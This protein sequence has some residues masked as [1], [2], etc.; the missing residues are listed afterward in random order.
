MSNCKKK[1]LVKMTGSIACFKACQLIS[2]LMQN[3]F[4]VQIV[5]SQAALKFIGAATLEG[6][7]G[8]KVISDLWE[9]G[10]AMAHIHLMRWADLI[11]VVPASANFINRV[12]QG[13]GEDLLTTL[14]LAHDFKKPYLI[15][16]AM[17]TSMYLHPVTQK[18]IQSLK[19]M[20]LI[21][22]ESASGVL[23]CGES[24]YGRLLE[25]DQ[26]FA[27]IQKA[28]N[29]QVAAAEIQQKQKTFGKVLITAGGTQE[30]IDDVR[31]LSNISTGKTAVKIAN[32]LSALGFEVVFIHAESS[33]LATE[34]SENHSF[35][36]SEDLDQQLKARLSQ[37]DI[38][39]V[40][41]MAAVSDYIPKRTPGKISSSEIPKIEL[42]PA[43]K[44]LSSLRSYAQNAIHLTAF[45]L[46]SQ[47]DTNMAKSAVEKLFKTSKPDWVVQNDLAEINAS[48]DHPAHLWKNETDLCHDF[49][50]IEEFVDVWAQMALARKE[51]N[52]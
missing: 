8:K 40:I 48:S 35:V 24:G 26:L 39:A 47:A 18:S 51:F 22:L 27:E 21:I 20:G 19:Q 13:L 12:A 30:F 43:K 6:L 9:P 2:K 25:P 33:A 3:N 5:A 49:K 34:P 41:H 32:K 4:D 15:A 14:F 7:T 46:T 37:G 31:V 17:N 1:I 38:Q 42:L 28:A 44:I 52:L 50:S 23:A 16:P 11:V 36:T 29:T 45:K 10:E